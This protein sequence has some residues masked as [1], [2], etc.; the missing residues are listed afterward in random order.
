[1]F[2]EMFWIRYMVISPSFHPVATRTIRLFQSYDS[3]R[4][5]YEL[6]TYTDAFRGTDRGK[7]LHK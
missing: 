2:I 6:Q 1:M 7:A 5:Q 3:N 4:T